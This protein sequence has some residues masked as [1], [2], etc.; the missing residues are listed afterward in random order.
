MPFFALDI[1]G[2][3]KED[4]V[5]VRAC[6]RAQCRNGKQELFELDEDRMDEGEACFR[7]GER[8]RPTHDLLHRPRRTDVF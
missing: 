4:G 2:D 8:N 7:T 6:V 1:G 3:E 5:G